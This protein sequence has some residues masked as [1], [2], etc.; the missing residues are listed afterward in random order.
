MRSCLRLRCLSACTAT[1]TNVQGGVA[2][3]RPSRKHPASARP[4]RP[5]DRLRKPRPRAAPPAVPPNTPTHQHTHTVQAST[6]ERGAGGTHTHLLEVLQV[7]GV[8][9]QP[10]Q[11]GAVGVGQPTAA[12]NI[13]EIPATAAPSVIKIPARGAEIEPVL[14]QEG[15]LLHRVG[16]GGR[17]RR[18]WSPA[19]NSAS[20]RSSKACASAY[21]SRKRAACSTLGHAGNCCTKRAQS[22]HAHNSYLPQAGLVQ[23]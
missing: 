1:A 10:R 2:S 18:Y 15:E 7:G 20:S 17:G 21:V 3:A 6:P 11:H 12:P 13:S 14:L 23:S 8:R 22:S 9:Q 4:A 19:A 5:E 16:L